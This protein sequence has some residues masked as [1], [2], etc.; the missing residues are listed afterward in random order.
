MEKNGRSRVHNFP[1]N[2]DKFEYW[3][4][5]ND[6]PLYDKKQ[7]RVLCKCRCGVES[8]VRVNALQSGESK[9]CRCRAADMRRKQMV[10]E[11]E[12]TKTK[13]NRIKKS[14]VERGLEFLITMKYA[15]EL[16]E[17]QKGKCFFSGLDLILNK[18]GENITASL[19][20]INSEIGYIEGNVQWVHKD[21]NKMKTDF[22]DDYFI[23]ICKLITENKNGRN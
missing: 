8:H 21:I 22:N 20:R 13:F 9:G 12:L 3:T 15:W 14:S 6:E 23:K 4:V 1:K 11:G 18:D 2:G 7:W 16:F 19:D 10:F 17:K 5:I